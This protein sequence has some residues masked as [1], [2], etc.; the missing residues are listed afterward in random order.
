MS[1]VVLRIWRGDKAGGDTRG[2]QSAAV[3]VAKA[4][5][6]YGGGNDRFIDFRVDDH[7]EPIPEL[8]RVLALRLRKPKE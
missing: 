2:K 7:K 1:Q 5:G 3:Y 6:G 4:K 8:A